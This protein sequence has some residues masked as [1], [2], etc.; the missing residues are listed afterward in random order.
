MTNQI[1][2]RVDTKIKRVFNTTASVVI[3]IVLAMVIWYSMGSCVYADADD[4]SGKCAIHIGSSNVLYV[5][6]Y[7]EGQQVIEQLQNQ[8]IAKN[9]KVVDVSVTP[10]ITLEE[11]ASKPV[12]FLSQEEP[13]DTVSVKDAVKQIMKLK[14]RVYSTYVTVKGDTIRSVAKEKKISAK[15]LVALNDNKYDADKKLKAGTSLKIYS[16][17]PCVSVQTVE[18]TVSTKKIAFKTVYKN[19][20]TL[21][22]GKTKVKTKGVKGSKKVVSHVTKINGKVVSKKVSSKK[23]VKKPVTKVVLK[24]TAD[25]T[26]KKGVTYDF[27]TG[28]DVVKYAKKFVGNPYVYGGTSLTHGCDCS[29]FVYSVYR[30]FGVQMPRTGQERVGKTVSVKAL[31]KGDILFYSGHVA[32]YAGNGKA[33]H[34]VNERL[35]I[36]VTDV[37]YTGSVLKA[38]RIFEEKQE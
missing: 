36:K 2:R 11:V 23:T 34:A 17:V 26:P 3:S 1:D 10:E 37:N 38:R 20:S 14:E 32:I 8:F 18:K 35:G 4:N 25:V 5:D 9:S 29:G 19:T 16:D 15:K 30:H 31:K 22:R 28:A 12:S 24:G 21:S 33:V 13:D 7:E 6:S 27:A